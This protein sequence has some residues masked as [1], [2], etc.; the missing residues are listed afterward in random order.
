M[1]IK[2]VAIDIDGTLLNN[3]RQI[4]PEVK[5]AITDATNQGVKI[6]LTTGRPSIGILD[7]IQELGLENEDNYMIAYNGAVIQNA[8]SKKVLLESPLDYNDYLEI[9]LLSR[10]LNIQLHVQDFEMMY[11]ANKEISPYTIHEASLTGIPLSYRPVSEMTPDIKIIKAM[12]IGEPNHLDDVIAKVPQQYKERLSMFKSAPFYYEILNPEATKGNAVHELA[13]LLGIKQEE[14]MA[15]GDNE[16][17]LSMIEYA[18]IGVAME[19]AL[20]SVKAICNKITLSNEEH[21]VAH[22]IREWVL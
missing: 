20:P 11:T 22:A 18:G 8:G 1:S 4:T 15:I 14:V 5:Q 6:V 9:E 21:G 7:V 17:D 16:N 3:E 12:Y 19:N 10:Q 2:L 13:T